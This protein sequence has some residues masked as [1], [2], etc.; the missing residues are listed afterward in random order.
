MT[1]TN[2]Q[3]RTVLKEAYLLAERGYSL[4]AMLKADC[5]TDDIPDHPE[6]LVF[7]CNV[8][9]DMDCIIQAE[10]VFQKLYGLE[11]VGL[12]DKLDLCDRLARY[13]A[14]AKN[15]PPQFGPGECKDA[16]YPLGELVVI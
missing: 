12:E 14:R 8:L 13:G 16:A 9:L 4:E 15:P 5:V 3:A 2:D 1:M 7:L 6:A 10:A 11:T